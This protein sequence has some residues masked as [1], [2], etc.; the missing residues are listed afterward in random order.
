LDEA[1]IDQLRKSKLLMAA[2]AIVLVGVGRNAWAQ[3]ERGERAAPDGPS[4]ALHQNGE[5]ATPQ[6]AAA[7]RC[8]M[9]LFNQNS[10]EQRGEAS[11]SRMRQG[12][13]NCGRG[14][15]TGQTT[16]SERRGAWNGGR[17][18]SMAGPILTA[19]WL[20]RSWEDRF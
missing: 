2:A 19:M 5:T 6:A 7:Q 9:V 14:E 4:G 17:H 16:P 12:Q 8:I 1:P 11:P 3:Q 18:V 13:Q 15:T 10:A 20:L